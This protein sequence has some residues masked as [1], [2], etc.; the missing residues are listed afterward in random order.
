VTTA[1]Q[2]EMLTDVPS[3]G[4]DLSLVHLGNR[5]KPWPVLLF[6]ELV[7]WMAPTL[8]QDLPT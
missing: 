4:E 7:A 6:K 8:F 3:I 5:N 2:A 1:T